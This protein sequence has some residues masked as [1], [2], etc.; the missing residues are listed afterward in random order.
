M[1]T[2]IAPYQAH[3]SVKNVNSAIGDGSPIIQ[4]M[5]TLIVDDV[6]EVELTLSQAGYRYY[7]EFNGNKYV[8]VSPELQAS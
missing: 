4:L 3:L 6:E 2:E 8:W 1:L 5:G 7:L